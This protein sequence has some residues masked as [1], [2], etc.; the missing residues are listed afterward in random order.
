M[1]VE[2]RLARRLQRRQAP[3]PPHG[4]RARYQLG[5]HCLP[6]RLANAEYEVLYDRQVARQARRQRE[7]V[8][9]K[10]ARAWLRALLA[11][12]FTK[13]MIA[14]ELGVT[15]FRGVGERVT[16]AR[17]CALERLYQTRV[18]DV[19]GTCVTESPE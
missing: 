19:D 3:L 14:R 8:R 2:S 7:L 9:A 16:Y 6:C 1:S 15:Q 17:H 11:E 10:Q 4:V 12:G 18:A 13:A 5:C